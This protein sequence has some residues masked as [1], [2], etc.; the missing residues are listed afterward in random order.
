MNVKDILRLKDKVLFTVSPDAPIA[1]AICLMDEN[2]IGAVVVVD[3]GEIVGMLTFREVIA[4]LARRL[5]ERYAGPTP[6]I[7]EIFVRDVMFANP[8][9]VSPE[10]DIDDLRR[11]MVDSKARY[12]PVVDGKTLI[13]AISLRD[14]ARGVLEE[15]NFENK[16]MKAY[17]YSSP[18][19]DD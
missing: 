18:V 19:K 5:K 16:A 6:P 1:E 4:I 11:L 10:M 15:K 7:L 13:C 8:P 12:V 17:I 2:D 14:I 3:N 9:I